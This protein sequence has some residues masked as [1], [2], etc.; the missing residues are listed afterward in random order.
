MHYYLFFIKQKKIKKYIDFTIF[1]LPLEKLIFWY[2]KII[3]KKKKKII[4]IIFFLL[5]ENEKKVNT[6]LWNKNKSNIKHQLYLKSF[7]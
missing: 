5:K 2:I 6:F 1:I 7:C 4:I 3:K